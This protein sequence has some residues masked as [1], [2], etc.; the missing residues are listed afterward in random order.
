MW[1]G[2]ARLGLRGVI[3]KPPWLQVFSILVYFLSVKAVSAAGYFTL[4]IILVASGLVFSSMFI[5]V[6]VLSPSHQAASGITGLV[7]LLLYLLS[8]YVI[9]RFLIPGWWIWF[10]WIQPFR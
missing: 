3:P 6:A 7:I 2:T 1:G 9:P 4:V 5:L 8:D 10:Y